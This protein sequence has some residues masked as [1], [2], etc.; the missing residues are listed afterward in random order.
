MHQIRLLRAGSR[1]ISEIK[2]AALLGICQLNIGELESKSNTCH[3]SRS[4]SVQ[5]VK[6]SSL[7]Q[8]LDSPLIDAS[9]VYP[10][11]KVEQRAKWAA[12]LPR[13]NDGLD[14]TL[15]CAFDSA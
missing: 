7:Y 15:P 3:G 9:S 10:D 4:V 6:G 11:A 5:R 2:Q 12:L 8:R 13:C 14:G 1:G